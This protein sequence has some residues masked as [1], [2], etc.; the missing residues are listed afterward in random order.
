MVRRVRPGAV[1]TEAAGAKA[2]AGGEMTERQKLWLEYIEYLSRKRTLFDT[3][4]LEARAVVELYR[5]AEVIA[6]S[7]CIGQDGE[8]HFYTMT[9]DDLRRLCA[10]VGVM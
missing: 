10:A 1:A 7:A 2:G 4:A 8:V 3:T 9:P 6:K 5:A